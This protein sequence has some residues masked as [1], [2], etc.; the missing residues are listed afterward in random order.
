MH[1]EE[2]HGFADNVAAA[3]NDGVGTF[4]LDVI[5]AQNFHAASG[6]ACNKTGATTDEAAE[7]DWVKSVDVLGRIDGFEDALGVDLGGKRELNE[8]AINIIVA[9]QIIDHGEHV[10]SS[11]RGR[12]SK[13]RAREADFFASGNFAFDVKLRCGIFA[14]EDGCKARANSGGRKQ[15][16]FVLEF[17][18]DLVANFGAV[19]DACGHAVLAFVMH[20]RCK[21]KS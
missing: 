7:V 19:E 4:D 12:G 13:E 5:A 21:R 3:E 11:Y 6:G 18:E 10:E 16:D 9:I 2:R 15:A 17:G 20:V 8:D 14:H 1:K